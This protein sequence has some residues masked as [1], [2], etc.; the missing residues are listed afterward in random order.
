MG[1]AAAAGRELRWALVEAA[2]MAVK[3]DPL[4]KMK[5]QAMQKRM[6]RNQAIVAV[7]RFETAKPLVGYAG[8]GSSVHD[9][10][11]PIAVEIV[12]SVDYPLQPH[13]SL[14]FVRQTLSVNAFDNWFALATTFRLEAQN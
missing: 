8:L 4:L 1:D 13:P 14:Q 11:Q 9:S 2:R 12:L 5:F 3:S 10:G 6:H 7:A